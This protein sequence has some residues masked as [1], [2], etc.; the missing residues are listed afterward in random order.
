MADRT[1]DDLVSVYSKDNT[2]YFYDEIDRVSIFKLKELMIDLYKKDRGTDKINL[3]IN[4]LGGDI[5]SLYYFIKAFPISVET[6]IEDYCCS[7]ATILFLA[8]SKRYIAPDGLFLIHSAHGEIEGDIGLKQV[9][10]EYDTTKKLNDIK[11]RTI[12]ELETKVPK[13]VLDIKFN[14]E[15]KYFTAEDCI[16]YKI[17]H[18]IKVFT[19]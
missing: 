17:A 15:E 18:E 9:E 16:K 11:M 13:K 8:G 2:I 4:S 19:V 6:Y 1:I 12:Y 5:G 10:E 14:G 7:A 3:I